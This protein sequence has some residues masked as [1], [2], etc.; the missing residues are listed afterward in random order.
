[1]LSKEQ[2]IIECEGDFYP[3]EQRSEIGKIFL[4]GVE[5]AET[6]YSVKDELP[7]I[8]DNGWSDEVI[9]KDNKNHYQLFAYSKKFNEWACIEKVPYFGKITHWRPN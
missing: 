3:I 6:W 8:E 9:C 4:A 2:A 7:E 1:M 5:H